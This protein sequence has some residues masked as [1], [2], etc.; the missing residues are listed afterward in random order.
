MNLRENDSTDDRTTQHVSDGCLRG[1]MISV[2][3][4]E[5]FE[6][7]ITST[8]LDF[9]LIG[10]LYVGYATS[11]ANAVDY[12]T[13][14]AGSWVDIELNVISPDATGAFLCFHRGSPSAE[15]NLGG[16]RKD[17]DTYDNFY[18]IRHFQFFWCAVASKVIEQKIDNEDLTGGTELDLWLWGYTGGTTWT[19]SDTATPGEDIYGLY[20]GLYGGSYNII[21]KKN[22]PFNYLVE[23]LADSASQEWGLKIYTP[24]VYSDGAPKMGTVTLT[25]TCS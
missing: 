2:D 22:S 23:G 11:F 17:G 7:K 25:A 5:I 8:T 12:S 21:V 13:G 3:S 9:Y 4:D 16:C 20:A 15:E 14:T 6:G 18:C 10:W 19:L 1:E 24:T